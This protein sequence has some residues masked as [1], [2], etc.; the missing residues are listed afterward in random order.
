M[1]GSFFASWSDFVVPFC[2]SNERAG[3][4]FSQVDALDYS[5]DG[6]FSLHFIVPE[7]RFDLGSRSFQ[8]LEDVEN[9]FFFGKKAFGAKRQIV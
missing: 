9:Y 2:F 6:I 1:V 3:R 4:V 8:F 5:F 7:K